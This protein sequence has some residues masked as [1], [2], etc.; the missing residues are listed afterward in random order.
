MGELSISIGQRLKKLR[1]AHKMTQ[2][3]LAEKADL[4][5]ITIRRYEKAERDLPM[6]TWIKLAGILGI[7]KADAEY[8]YL[9]DMGEDF[10]AVKESAQAENRLTQKGVE[11]LSIYFDLTDEGQKKVLAYAR[12]IQKGYGG[13]LNGQG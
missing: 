7:N 2:A 11:L 9:G 4:S 13:V 10:Q 12:D 5:P 3:Q 8:F 1:K 6:E